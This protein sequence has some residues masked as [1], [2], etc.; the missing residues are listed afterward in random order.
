MDN[1]TSAI[2]AALRDEIVKIGLEKKQ[3]QVLVERKDKVF[4]ILFD[5]IED[6][7]ILH[8]G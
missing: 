5:A 1:E 4:K 6:L 3:L 7:K 8:S 2:I